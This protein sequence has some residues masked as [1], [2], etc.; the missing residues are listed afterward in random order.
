MSMKENEFFTELRKS[1]RE[2]T[3]IANYLLEHNFMHEYQ[4]MIVKIRVI[5]QILN[6]H[7][8]TTRDNNT[9]IPNFNFKD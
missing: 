9:L 5:N 3:V 7:E 4:H 1:C 6:E 8:R 2:M